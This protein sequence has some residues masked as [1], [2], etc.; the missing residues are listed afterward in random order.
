V[1]SLLKPL[2]FRLDPERAH[3]LVFGLLQTLGPVARGLARMVYGPP[4]PRLACDL[5]GLTL[6]GPVGL[7][8][9][10]DKNG[11][12]SQF[13]PNLGFGFVEVGTVTALAQPGNPQPRL[14]RFPEQQALINRMGFNNGGSQ[15]LAVRLKATGKTS[16][17]CGVNLGK[18]KV[19]PLDEAVEDYRTSAGRV[20]DV[21]DYLVI[22]VS[23]P[24]TPGLRKLQDAGF[25][26]EISAAVLAEAPGIPVFIK[27]APDLTDDALGEAVAVAENTGAAGIIATNTTIERHGLPDVG[28]GGLSGAPLRPRSLDVI[29]AVCERTALPVIGVGGISNAEHALQVLAAGAACVQVY[30]ALIFQGPGLVSRINKD[31]VARMDRDGLKSMEELRAALK[32]QRAAD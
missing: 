30:S 22:N 17:P 7:A 32:D 4:D 13:W 26:R 1:Y 8:A 6:A 12:L 20:R 5:A 18:S 14:F 31:L 16:V 11:M 19:T 9:G 23:S 21:A 10:L 2:L 27:L 25:L 24:N 29:R 3:H 28:A 15:A